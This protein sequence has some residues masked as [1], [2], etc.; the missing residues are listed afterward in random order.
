VDLNKGLSQKMLQPRDGFEVTTLR[1]GDVLITGGIREMCKFP[2]H[3]PAD[4]IEVYRY[5]GSTLG[6]P[7]VKMPKKLSAPQGQRGYV[8]EDFKY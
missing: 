7:P 1:N 2:Y 5:S 6:N 4:A 8:L 3:I